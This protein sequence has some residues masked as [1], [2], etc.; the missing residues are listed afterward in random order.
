MNIKKLFLSNLNPSNKIMRC[1]SKLPLAAG[2][3]AALLSF[4]M[5]PLGAAAAPDLPKPTAHTERQIEG[6][7]V[8]LDDR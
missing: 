3:A 6:W 4:A 8:R 5:S 1:L 2:L 7:T